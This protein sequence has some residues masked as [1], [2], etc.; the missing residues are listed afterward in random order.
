MLILEKIYEI[1]ILR[2][3]ISHQLYGYIVLD[4]T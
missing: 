3:S 4:I 2:N 1:T